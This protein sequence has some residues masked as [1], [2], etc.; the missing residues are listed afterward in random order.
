MSP[1]TTAPSWRRA[2]YG[3]T[4]GQPGQSTGGRA[5]RAGEGALP[6]ARAPGGAA[7]LLEEGLEL[8]DDDEPLDLGGEAADQLRGER[9]AQAE[10]QHARLRHHPA[11]RGV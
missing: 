5:P 8:L 2:R 9:G 3:V 1:L 4:C 10:L 11:P 6:R 7:R